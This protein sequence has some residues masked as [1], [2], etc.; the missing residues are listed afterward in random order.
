MKYC[1]IGIVHYSKTDD[2]GTQGINR[3]EAMKKCLESLFENTDYPAEVIIFD[4]GGNPDDT[5]W[6]TQKVREGKINTLVRYKENL[7]FAFAWNQFAR[8]AT[9]DYLCFTNND[10]IFKP[11]WLSKTIY[12]I[13]NNPDRK[14][15]STPFITPDKNRP[16]FNK[17]VL[18][19]GYRI[20]SLAGSNCMIMTHQIWKDVG[21][22]PHHRISG[23][24]WHRVASHKGYM[25]IAPPVDYVDHVAFRHGVNWHLKTP[26]EK[27]L[28]N[29]EIVDFHFQ[30]YQK[31]L[32]HG[33]QK[34]AGMPLG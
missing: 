14:L 19:D 12:G 2:H 20:N 10:I 8:I 1:S 17:E 28:L 3:S 4:N 11:Q 25:F 16:R 32:S 18:P 29:G 31:K 24:I 9:G 23:T 21:E 33:T 6:L 15:I 13:E 22:F 34:R 30:N 27:K 26:V 5:D 7:S